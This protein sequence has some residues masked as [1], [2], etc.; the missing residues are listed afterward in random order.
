MHGYYL[1]K[2]IF[3]WIFASLKSLVVLDSLVCTFCLRVRWVVV[4]V[5]G[6]R[7]NN[8]QPETDSFDTVRECLM[9][10]ADIHA[11]VLYDSAHRLGWACNPE[12]VSN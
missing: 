4:A 5:Y 1:G 10:M 9:V 12:R 3:L 8:Q 7:T 6:A 2:R 11:L